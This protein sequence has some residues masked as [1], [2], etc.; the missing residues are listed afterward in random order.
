MPTLGLA[1]PAV[2]DFHPT[3]LIGRVQPAGTLR[4]DALHVA[5]ADLIEEIAAVLRLV[6][7]QERAGLRRYQSPQDPLA[8]QKRQHP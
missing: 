1:V 7:V 6:M 4:N 3:G 8:L 2:L 5:R